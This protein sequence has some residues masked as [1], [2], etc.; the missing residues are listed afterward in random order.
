MMTMLFQVIFDHGYSDQIKSTSQVQVSLAE[1][2]EF[3]W[4]RINPTAVSEQVSNVRLYLGIG[5]N[6]SQV[7]NEKLESIATTS[8][9]NSVSITFADNSHYLYSVETGVLSG[10]RPPTN[11][12]VKIFDS[13]RPE[14]IERF[15]GICRAAGAPANIEFVEGMEFGGELYHIVASCRPENQP[16]SY[17]TGIE[18]DM[19]VR[20]GG[21]NFVY[22]TEFPKS[23]VAPTKKP[24]AVIDIRGRAAGA[25]M[26]MLG[27]KEAETGV[28]KPMFGIPQL[29]KNS[30]LADRERA[31]KSE[32]I[33]LYS[34]IVS[35]ANSWSP[36]KNDFMRNAWVILEAETGR[37]LSAQNL[38]SA[39]GG[40]MS[41]GEDKLRRKVELVPES[42]RWR[43]H[44]SK[45]EGRLTPAKMPRPLSPGVPIILT[46]DSKSVQMT[47][48]AQ[49]GLLS[50]QIDEAVRAFVPDQ[51][52]RRALGK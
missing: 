21:V 17:M 23:F 42:M 29:Y 20:T 16:Y 10:F 6:A 39:F 32:A 27:W 26:N 25:A 1:L 48:H 49:E 52:L 9:G 30:T 28:S 11:L 36:Q 50:L 45:A 12:S 15:L 43:L 34:A 33:L 41:A 46:S 14:L 8:S 40:G 18:G 22:W 19:D 5:A 7:F 37:V 3:P 38:G 4:G 31:K 35:E 44:Q 51:S 47:W 13:S 24:M 2:K